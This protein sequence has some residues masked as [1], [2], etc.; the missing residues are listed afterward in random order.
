M[1]VTM[2]LA[3]VFNDVDSLDT[4]GIDDGHCDPVSDELKPARFDDHRFGIYLLVGSGC[5]VGHL[6]SH[7]KS[8]WRPVA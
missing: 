7:D 8:L 3:L 1:A 6:V 4:I 5:P 2:A